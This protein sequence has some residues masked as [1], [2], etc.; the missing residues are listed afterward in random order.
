MNC[1]QWNQNIWQIYGLLKSLH[2]KILNLPIHCPTFLL[3]EIKENHSVALTHQ[4]KLMKT[5][6]TAASCG[7]AIIRSSKLHAEAFRVSLWSD[8]LCGLSEIQL[9]AT[10]M[11]TDT[12]P[13]KLILRIRSKKSHRLDQLATYAEQHWER[14]DGQQR[15]YWMTVLLSGA[16]RSPACL[17][18]L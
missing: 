10:Q 7:H 16:H 4:N 2:A 13:E 9:H 15:F 6:Q 1:I 18:N 14:P 3:Q 5:S 8:P 17:L 12:M 11:C